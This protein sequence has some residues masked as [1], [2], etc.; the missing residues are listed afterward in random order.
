MTTM[1]D[2]ELE[3]WDIR[4]LDLCK[5]VSTWS[6]DPST[7]VGAVIVDE[8]RRIVSIGFNGLPAGVEDTPERLVDRDNKLH[9]VVHGDANA[10]LFAQRDLR[11]CTMYTYPFHP[12]ARCAGLIIQSGIISVISPEAPEE[13]ETR[14]GDSLSVAREMFDEAGV[15]LY[16]VR[17]K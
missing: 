16:M 17:Y 7:K 9:M 8:N 4:F 5:L 3:N 13:V 12:C 1:L 15:E 2:N 11:G 14:W 6:K 10:I